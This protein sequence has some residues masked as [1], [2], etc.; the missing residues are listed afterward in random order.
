MTKISQDCVRACRVSFPMFPSVDRLSKVSQSLLHW[1]RH[2]PTT[3]LYQNH[4]RLV[5]GICCTGGAAHPPPICIKITGAWWVESAAT[6]GAA[7]PPGACD[8]PQNCGGYMSLVGQW[9]EAKFPAGINL[10]Q[11]MAPG[12]RQIESEVALDLITIPA[13]SALPGST[14]HSGT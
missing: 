12:W 13:V 11:T 4:R 8:P 3:H 2:S 5:G 6:G 14:Q 7:H 10:V 9:E 1:W